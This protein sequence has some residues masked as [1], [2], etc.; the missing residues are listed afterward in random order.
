M[1]TTT[2]VLRSLPLSDI[3]A[4][5]LDNIYIHPGEDTGTIYFIYED[6]TCTIEAEGTVN[7]LWRE[8]GDDWFTPRTLIPSDTTG[9]I[10]NIN[11]WLNDDDNDQSIHL[12]QNHPITTALTQYLDNKLLNH[13]QRHIH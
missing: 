6:N 12:P 13:I 11:I 9:Y 1:I 8:Y 7:T 10:D 2:S 4:E 3:T 5:M